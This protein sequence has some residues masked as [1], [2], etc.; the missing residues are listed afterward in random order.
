MSYVPRVICARLSAGRVRVYKNGLDGL[1][2]VV[3]VLPAHLVGDFQW[4]QKGT[5]P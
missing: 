4:F 2:P 5:C 1:L 3:T